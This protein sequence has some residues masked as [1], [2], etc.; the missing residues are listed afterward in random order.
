MRS[1]AYSLT[2]SGPFSAYRAA[3]PI[4]LIGNQIADS[5]R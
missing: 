4:I 2:A 5:V 3:F 1:M